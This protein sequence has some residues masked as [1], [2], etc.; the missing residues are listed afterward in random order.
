[1]SITLTNALSEL[2]K[3]MGDFWSS[4]TTSGG[5]ST[6]VIDTELKAKANDWIADAPQEMYDRITSGTYDGEERKI[7]SLDNTSGT[8]T[9]LAHGG[10]IATSVTYEVHRLFSASEKRRALIY[11]ARHSFPSLYRVVRDENL[12]IGNWLRDPGFEWSWTTSALNTYWVASTVTQAKNTTAPYYS[13]GSTSLKLSTAA[14]YSYQSNTQNPDLMD[15]AGQS[16]TFKADV[17]SDV[18]S[19]TRLQIY[20]GT[21]T[22]YSDYHTGDNA[23]ANLSVTATIA[24]TPS[25]VR[26]SYVRAGATSTVYVD[27]AIVTGPTRNKLYIG[28]LDIALDRPHKLS[29][30]D[31]D[32]NSEPW[33]TIRSYEIGNDGYIYLH[34]GTVENRL[35]IEGMGYLNLIAEA[36]MY[37]Y[38]QMISP[39]YT[40]GERDKF[41]QMLQYW[42]KELEVR[43]GRFKMKPPPVM[44]DWGVK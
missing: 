6:T 2:S 3:Q 28:D 12:T 27:N 13:R 34:E 44:I 32:I 20:D 26:F 11:A 7:S 41:A 22:T 43:K 8:L 37:L 14:G 25:T 24:S 21:T 19:D 10:T 4:T 31:D 15:L 16:V 40:S 9:T 30:T 36:I 29:E 39:N 33:S 23:K 17:W 5:S 35:R 18:A 42:E 38:I 1:M